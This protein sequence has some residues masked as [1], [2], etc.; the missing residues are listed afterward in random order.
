MNPD[1]ESLWSAPANSPC[2]C[3]TPLP[4]SVSVP[5]L[6][7]PNQAEYVP[8]FAIGVCATPANGII[9]ANPKVTDNMAFAN[10]FI[11]FLL[12]P[13]VFTED[14]DMAGVSTCVFC[15]VHENRIQDLSLD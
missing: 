3:I 14:S 6:C 5:K 11:I 1:P 13:A 10:F 9:R 2:H 8:L 7:H 4:R 12:L 15:V